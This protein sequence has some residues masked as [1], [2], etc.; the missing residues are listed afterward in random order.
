MMG[1]MTRIACSAQA[2]RRE[3]DHSN[4]FGSSVKMSSITLLSTRTS[5][6]L[7]SRQGHNF[8]GRHFYGP[9]TAQMFYKLMPA[10]LAALLLSNAH[11]VSDDVENHFAVGKQT[12]PLADVLRNSDL[13]LRCHAHSF[14]L[15]LTNL[16]L[17]Y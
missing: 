6:T 2:A 11:T 3:A 10:V 1:L 14:S 4:H 13:S 15:T 7:F 5:V 17:T 16:T 8:V 12:E 9:F